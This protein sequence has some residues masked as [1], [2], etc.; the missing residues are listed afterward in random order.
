[1][2]AEASDQQAAGDRIYW[3]IYNLDIKNPNAPEAE[4]HDPD[5]L[6]IQY[7]QLL[8][9]IEETQSLLKDELATA[10]AHHFDEEVQPE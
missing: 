9:D 7:K 2:R 5:Q 1:L 6:L 8:L 3:P 4:V 10:L